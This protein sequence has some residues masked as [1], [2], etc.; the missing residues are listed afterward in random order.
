MSDHSVNR[1]GATEQ[2]VGRRTTKGR[3][4][5]RLTL[6]T[7]LALLASLAVAVAVV[8][9]SVVAYLTTSRTLLSQ[10]DR[11][12]V[13]QPRP[14]GHEPE[15]LCQRREPYE[16]FLLDIQVLEAGGSTCSPTPGGLPVS[17]ADLA[18]AA[19]AS[20]Q[21]LHDATGSDGAHLRIRTTPLD[22][23]Y[24]L[25][26]AYPLRDV[27]TSLR[28][29]GIVLIVVSACGVVAA[30]T[31]GL[32]IARTALAPVD[33]LTGAAE[34][35]ARTQ[36][37]Q[38]PI[39]V[40]GSDEIARLATAFNAMTSAL[41]RSR[42]RQRQLVADASHELRT[43]LTSL[44]TNIELLQRSERTGRPLPE[45]DRARLLA[46]VNSQ[47]VEL[48]EIVGELVDLAR[49]EPAVAPVDRLW[50]DEVVERA[51]ERARPRNPGVPVVVVAERAGVTG[52]A[53]E[54]ERAV[55][56]LLDNALKFSP[57]GSTVRAEVHPCP[58]GVEV[59]VLDQGPGISDADLPHVFERFW[60]SPSARSLPG[61]GL[62]LAIV[63]DAVRRHGGQVRLERAEGGGTVAR[64]RLPANTAPE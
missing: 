30:A 43:P 4:W 14:Q 10:V 42:E 29:L 31:A 21:A 51:A 32:V 22:S 50:V 63:A 7:R 27:D 26:E 12:L 59:S 16:R 15:E 5:R 18:V 6:R 3:G 2:N 41:A 49:D 8:A 25:Q 61:S 36:D 57:P 35:I 38:V 54:L 28:R 60:R 53:P 48:G 24:A 52:R 9:V 23:G 58:G 47:L 33:E 62:G 13:T 17:P 40:R 44:R 34:H 20:Q 39:P 37:L 64:I 55:L 45:R 19:G 1:R 56:N 46:D 11:S